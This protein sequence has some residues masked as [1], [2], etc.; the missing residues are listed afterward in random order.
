MNHPAAVEA[1]AETCVL[2]SAITGGPLKQSLAGT[3]AMNQHGEV[4]AVGGVNEKIEGFF[5]VCTQARGVNGHGA[6]LPASNVEHLMLNEQ[7]RDAVREEIGRAS[8]SENMY[9]IHD[10]PA[11]KDEERG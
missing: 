7:V 4:Q 9:A 2:L 6:L 11:L 1:V 8:C 3:G 5:N 10:K